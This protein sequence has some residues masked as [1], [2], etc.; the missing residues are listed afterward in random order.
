MPNKKALKKRPPF[1]VNIILN[2]ENNVTD[3]IRLRSD[4][5][6]CSPQ[7]VNSQSEV[8]RESKQT[9]EVNGKVMLVL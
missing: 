9:C 6:E 3:V 7:E 8:P 2:I 4:S 5:E 1:S